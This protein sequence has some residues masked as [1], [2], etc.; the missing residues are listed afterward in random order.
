MKI[1]VDTDQVAGL[2][3]EGDKILFSSEGE[4]V[5]VK[6]L[7]LSSLVNDAIQDVKLQLEKSALEL[8]PN[9]V[10][11]QGDE[12]KVAYRAFGVRYKIDPQYVSQL[13]KDL[14]ETRVSYG[15]NVKAIDAYVDEKGAL[16]L[17]I[18]TP[19]RPKKISITTK[20]GGDDEKDSE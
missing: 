16:P 20:K 1:T 19:E 7:E 15:P 10:S 6:L 12:I 2:K 9:F 18:D 11:I 14:Y 17:G 13:P 8:D 3:K 5:I 4:A